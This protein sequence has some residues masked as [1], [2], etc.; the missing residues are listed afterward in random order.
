MEIRLIPTHHSRS[1]GHILM[2]V[3]F[4]VVCSHCCCHFFRSGS[5]NYC[6]SSRGVSSSAVKKECQHPPF[7]ETGQFAHLGV[8]PRGPPLPFLVLILVPCKQPVA[9]DPPYYPEVK[10]QKAIVAGVAKCVSRQL[11]GTPQLVQGSREQFIIVLDVILVQWR[12]Q[13]WRP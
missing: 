11:V 9:Q 8:V 1:H 2:H 3:F 4:S 13:Q 12:W 5:S 7:R 6:C 10:E